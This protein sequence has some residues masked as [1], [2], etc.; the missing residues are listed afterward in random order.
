MLDTFALPA[1][2]RRNL[3]QI[4]LETRPV[5]DGSTAYVITWNCGL[6]HLTGI[7]GRSVS[8]QLVWD[9]NSNGCGFPLR[10][11]DYWIQT[12]GEIW[13]IMVLDI[14]DPTAPQLATVLPLPDGFQPHW[15]SAEPGGNRIVLTGYDALSDR[16]V[17]LKWDARVEH[18]SVV[19]DFGE[20]DD[21]LPGFMTNRSIWPHGKTGEAT[22]HGAMFWPVAENP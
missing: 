2:E 7:G 10:I 4:P 6:Y 17:M 20:P 16:I 14:S 5:G 9:F 21:T 13:Q 11:G 3:Q 1:G 19:G 18:L 8:A 15:M 12:V 22:A